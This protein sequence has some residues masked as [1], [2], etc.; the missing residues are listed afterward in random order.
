MLSVEV[1]KHFI[2]SLRVLLK[3][4]AATLLTESNE[5]EAAQRPNSAG[6]HTAPEPSKFSMRAA[7]ARAPLQ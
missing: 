3:S 5:F 2:S 1:K 6:A 4:F 7:L